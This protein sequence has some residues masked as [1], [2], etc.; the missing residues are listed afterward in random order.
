MNSK[1][2]VSHDVTVRNLRAP[3]PNAA[4]PGLALR[5]RP[6]VNLRERHPKLYVNNHFYIL[7]YTITCT[8]R[9]T[10]TNCKHKFHIF[11]HIN[12]ALWLLHYP[13]TQSFKETLGQII[14]ANPVRCLLIG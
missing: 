7:N 4:R 3:V 2:L 8:L 12:S 11:T 10:N 1:R 5:M 6:E 9:R 14:D 13:L